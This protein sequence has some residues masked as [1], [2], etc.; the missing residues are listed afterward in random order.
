MLLHK[1][2]HVR[3]VA[4]VLV[5]IFCFVLAKGRRE[6]KL[7][8]NSAAVVIP[9]QNFKLLLKLNPAKASGSDLLPARISSVSMNNYKTLS[10]R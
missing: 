4:V 7:E 10:A 3:R 8:P 9:L 6:Q 5:S 1:R 2:D